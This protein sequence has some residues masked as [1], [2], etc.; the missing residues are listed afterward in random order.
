M[1]YIADPKR[2]EEYIDDFGFLA[3]RQDVM[4]QQ[5]ADEPEKYAFIEMY[6]NSKT[7]EFNQTWPR[8]SL[9]MA[10]ALKEILLEDGDIQTILDK[11]AEEIEYI[12][13]GKQ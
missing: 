6:K 8:I 3:P 11:K 1:K 10:D 9:T 5:F 13:E 4:D 12:S 2:M 7:R